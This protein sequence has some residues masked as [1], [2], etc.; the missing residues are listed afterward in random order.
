MSASLQPPPLLLVPP[1]PYFVSAG[2]KGVVQADFVSVESA[3]VKDIQLDGDSRWICK[4]GMERRYWVV[5]IGAESK[6]IS[7]GP[8]R[9]RKEL[10]AP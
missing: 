5:L 6:A 10:G 9:I 8:A 4:C 1:P 3:G 2:R 7:G